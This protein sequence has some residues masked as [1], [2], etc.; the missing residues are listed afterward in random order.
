MQIGKYKIIK[1]L[2][3]TSKWELFLAKH[4]DKPLQ[5]KIRVFNPTLTANEQSR[6]RLL[7]SLD[8]FYLM[9]NKYFISILEYGFLDKNVIYEV[10]EHL[11]YLN[12]RN[13]I[14][15]ARRVPQEIA[16]IIL[17]EI[18]SGL[19]QA[20]IRGLY[21][22]YLNP[23]VIVTSTSGVVKIQDISFSD[24][25]SYFHNFICSEGLSNSLYYA[26]EHILQ[27]SLDKRTDLFL[28]GVISYEVLTG[29]HPFWTA[30][31]SW[32]VHKI[33]T[34]N[35]EP[36]FAYLPHIN[37]TLESVVEKLMQ[38]EVVNRYQD[39][40]SAMQDL[41]SYIK[42]LGDYKSYEILSYYFNDPKNS[43]EKL[44]NDYFLALYDEARINYYHKNYKRSLFQMQIIEKSGY[45]FEGVEVYIE[46]IMEKKG[47]LPINPNILKL[48][49]EY[50]A[51]LEFE[52]NNVD[53]LTKL[54]KLNLD[55]GHYCDA[56]YYAKKALQVQSNN[57]EAIEIISDFIDSKEIEY[58]NI[59]KPSAI[60]QS[61]DEEKGHRQISFSIFNK[62]I[63]IIVFL[64]LII[65]LIG[66]KGWINFSSLIKEVSAY[67]LDHKC[68]KIPA[69]IYTEL[70][71][72]LQNEKERVE[73]EAII[74]KLIYFSKLNLSSRD[75]CKV[76][77]YLCKVYLKIKDFNS[78]KAL[79][80]KL[81]R[82][83]DGF[84]MVKD[85]YKEYAVSMEEMGNLPEA[86]N[87]YIE[88]LIY[89]SKDDPDHVYI[90]K[91]VKELQKIILGGI[92][93]KLENED[94]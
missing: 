2:Q 40:E 88:M 81:R 68:D 22:G 82:N 58:E 47:Y 63:A 61:S 50:K 60:I 69:E 28:A 77:N 51:K 72:K 35:P 16:G 71:N 18:L 53:I 67:D 10:I 70:D 85:V 21:H 55:I 36:L 89:L 26:P 66:Y 33:L 5:V 29:R 15:I 30:D 57:A 64:G 49:D 87:I 62:L 92:S 80:E 11:D 43:T 79:L 38:K 75:Y 6:N 23:S 93:I 94:N 13:I 78:C 32:D 59:S 9:R 90:E 37:P 39:A 84:S 34:L 7:E 74:D 46:D 76:N 65:A 54:A 31:K 3:K 52:P 91:K 12:L 48:V 24:N 27:K 20:H 4:I 45:K 83:C 44:E 8:Y 17:K 86:L 41:E 14:N 73:V 25:E 1:A 19:E 56:L 42:T